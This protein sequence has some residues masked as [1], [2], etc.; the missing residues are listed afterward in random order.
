MRVGTASGIQSGERNESHREAQPAADSIPM[1][2][3][4]EVLRNARSTSINKTEQ[5]GATSRSSIIL[6]QM[7]PGVYAAVGKHQV[8]R[9]CGHA[10]PTEERQKKPSH[11]RAEC[12]DIHN[13]RHPDLVE[14][15]LP[16]NAPAA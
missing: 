1:A 12:H 10:D 6:D 14:V 16:R 15:A 11:K 5:P 13:W 3:V 4:R 2:R 7:P 8:Q 9:Q